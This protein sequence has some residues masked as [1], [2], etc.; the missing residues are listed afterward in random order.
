MFDANMRY[1][2][3]GTKFFAKVH[4]LDE[5]SALHS[6]GIKANDLIICQ[7][8]DDDHTAPSIIIH[9]EEEVDAYF[10]DSLTE[11]SWI[12]YEGKYDLTDFINK[13]S[14]AIAKRMLNVKI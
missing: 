13:K 2:K 3:A 14:L 4:Y 11:D 8:M 5:E 7:M 12:V 9:L 10:R 1:L 6:Y